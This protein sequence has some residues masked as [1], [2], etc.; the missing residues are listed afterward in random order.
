MNVT[1]APAAAYV[2]GSPGW[3]NAS[4][5]KSEDGAFAS[6]S[7]SALS[8]L[9]CA[10]FGATFANADLIQGLK[11]RVKARCSASGQSASMSVAMT[12]DGA[13]I[14][15][16][17]KAAV[18][19][20]TFEWIELGGIGDL[21]GLNLAPS[22][23][24]APTFGVL[25]ASTAT[26]NQV[27]GGI[28]FLVGVTPGID[29]DAVE[30]VVSVWHEDD[31]VTMSQ[32]IASKQIALFTNANGRTFRLLKLGFDP[33]FAPTFKTTPH[34]GG[35]NGGQTHL[36]SET[37]AVN[38]VFNDGG[39]T[40]DESG[41]V[42]RQL[43]GVEQTET[44][45]SGVY[46]HV[47]E[48]RQFSADNIEDATVYFGDSWRTHKST[49]VALKSFGMSYSA[50]DVSGVS[51]SGSGTAVDA[52]ATRPTAT[53]ETQTITASGSGSVKLGFKGQWTNALTLPLDASAIEAAL[54]GLSTID[55]TGSAG[56]SVTGT[57]PFVV[58]FDGPLVSGTNVPLLEYAVA[59][60]TPT[61][62]I[63][64]T[65]RGG[66]STLD[67]IP[68][69]PGR[70]KLYVSETLG[71]LSSGLVTSPKT[72]AYQYGD[73]R[74]DDKALDSTDLV[75]HVDQAGTETYTFF[76]RRGTA[77]D[78][79][80]AGFRSNSGRRYVR[81]VIEGPTISGVHK[82]EL[83]FEMVGDISSITPAEVM[84]E[85]VGYSF[86]VTVA[87]DDSTGFGSRV[88]LQNKVASYSA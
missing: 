11:V 76:V 19:G 66:Y 59:S 48:A 42:F 35:R 5:A 56:V 80:I 40:F 58:E 53:N 10:A 41:F 43:F 34:L 14:A 27:I 72:F 55:T 88:W 8:L 77:T 83:G 51:A 73:A 6:Y 69:L 3:S 17:P 39:L 36:L 30:L 63:A 7:G 4:S 49:K 70:G 2:V 45:A 20:D 60:G 62:A 65:Q 57:G 54:S 16:V 26:M 78:A 47:F 75:G 81:F 21:F 12:L 22:D 29:V 28:P 9:A 86:T 85:I 68:V 50:S 84:D 61:I 74:T 38:V 79:L 24:N 87:P 44:V 67:A 18:V 46:K 37:A 82:H 1:L 31:E 52:A 33:Q 32:S 25:I 71:G 13:S 15:G 23:V 64:E